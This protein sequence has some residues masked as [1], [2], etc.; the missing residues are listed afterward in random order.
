[1]TSIPQTVSMEREVV[2]PTSANG[3]QP[4][5]GRAL[6]LTAMAYFPAVLCMM[7][8]G[9][10]VPFIDTLT[11]DLA[12]GHAQ[13]GLSIA[14]FSVPAAFL[15]TISGGLIDKYG[16]R[17]SV[18]VSLAITVLGSALASQ[19]TSLLLFDGT[20]VLGGLGFGGAC[21]AGPC[22]IIAALEG[23]AR[24]RAM[25]FFA[26]FAPTGYAAGLL[27]AVP[28]S[29]AGNGWRSALLTHAA[30]TL[31]AFLVLLWWLPRVRAVPNDRPAARSWESIVSVIRSGRALRLAVA[32]AL[33]N[34]VSYGTSLAAPSYLARIHHL[35][36]GTSST[37]VA[38]AKIIAMVIGGL[39]I[40]QLLSRAM[41]ASLLYGG[42]VLLGIL[43]QV[44]LFFP[45]SGITASTGALV[46]WLFAFGGM[47]GGAMAL[48]PAVV[49]DP[50]RSGAASG[51]VNQF[52]SLGSFAAPS[53]WLS[54][55]SWTQYVLLAV[56]C[57]VVA[58]VALPTASRLSAR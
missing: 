7:T 38:T 54:M 12:T 34:V 10:V 49:R 16:V 43:A 3:S 21:V 23:R 50:A 9:V 4:T 44:V 33:P 58:F 29:D 14:L 15:A 11:R 30:L 1:M 48:L 6:A 37:A 55:Q 52:I 45:E 56:C 42:M 13:I 39:S 19:S 8:V 46:V 2:Y 5:T 31:S 25:S 32:V 27:L 26:T 53:I 28:F 47:S 40:G 51:L 57:L 41:S 18:L 36:I 22:L 17:L 24:T 35:T 20:M